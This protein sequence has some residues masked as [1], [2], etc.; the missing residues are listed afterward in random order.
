MTDD[1]SILRQPVREAVEYCDG[2]FD[3][4]DNGEWA[5]VRA[6]LL[7]LYAI[8]NG[9][10]TRCENAEVEIAALRETAHYANGVADLAMKRRDTAEA[11][12]AALKARIAAAC[13]VPV[14]KVCLG[15][16]YS[17]TVS[18][19]MSVNDVDELHGKR[20]RLVVEE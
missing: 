1:L 17:L 6:E 13:L 12:L 18:A 4:A 7:R 8:Q 2:I 10:I 9:L 20:V 19:S 5:C 11:E 16:G 15:N 3:D 14:T